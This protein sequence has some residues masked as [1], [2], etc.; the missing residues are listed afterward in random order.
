MDKVIETLERLY[1]EQYNHPIQ[2]RPKPK[3]GVTGEEPENIKVA[4]YGDEGGNTSFSAKK[5][6]KSRNRQFEDEDETEDNEE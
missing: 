2:T 6:N 4:D 3:A 5:V 1:K